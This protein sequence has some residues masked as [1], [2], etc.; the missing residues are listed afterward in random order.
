MYRKEDKIKYV[1][2]LWSY[3]VM[4]L[5][6]IEGMDKKVYNGRDIVLERNEFE[7]REVDF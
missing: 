4:E 1:K 6:K 7:V 5:V 3:G 2:G